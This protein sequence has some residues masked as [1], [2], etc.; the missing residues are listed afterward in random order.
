MK[1]HDF[2]N[3]SCKDINLPFISNRSTVSRQITKLA[4]QCVGQSICK[5]VNL[6]NKDIPVS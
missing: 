5:F 6:N 2:V 4:L 3:F 1:I